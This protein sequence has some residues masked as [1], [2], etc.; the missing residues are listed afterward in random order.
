MKSAFLSKFRTSTRLYMSIEIV[1]LQVQLLYWSFSKYSDSA[2]CVANVNKINKNPKYRTVMYTWQ[3]RKHL[4]D[5]IYKS[6]TGNMCIYQG[7]KNIENTRKYTYRFLKK[8]RKRPFTNR[9]IELSDHRKEVWLRQDM[10][11]WICH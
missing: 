7:D 3:T 1:S 2:Q 10:K 6:I 8:F 9:T 11:F 4:T 5:F